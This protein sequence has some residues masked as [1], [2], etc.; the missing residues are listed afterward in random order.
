[1]SLSLGKSFDRNYTMRV[2]FLDG[3]YDIGVFFNKKSNF[4][5]FRVDPEFPNKA[6]VPSSNKITMFKN[7]ESSFFS[8]TFLDLHNY[9][10][11]SLDI[12]NQFQ[13]INSDYQYDVSFVFNETLNLAKVDV[14]GKALFDTL[15]LYGLTLTAFPSEF[16]FVVAERQNIVKRLNK[17]IVRTTG[18]QIATSPAIE[19]LNEYH[20]Q[21][22][23]VDMFMQPKTI[24]PS[25]TKETIKLSDE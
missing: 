7:L 15:T 1:M 17:K 19:L 22:N 3:F 13:G 23:T 12:M 25:D 20:K 14:G 10:N 4:L 9:R 2:P 6:T 18:V 16:I 24:I 5:L 8:E 21:Q 11:T